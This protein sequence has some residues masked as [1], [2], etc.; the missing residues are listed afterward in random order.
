MQKK[1]K[2]AEAKLPREVT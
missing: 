1:E 2:R